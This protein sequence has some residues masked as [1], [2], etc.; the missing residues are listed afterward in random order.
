MYRSFSGS[1]A[2]IQQQPD[3]AARPERPTNGT[4]PG[5]PPGHRGPLRSASDRRRRGIATTDH[6]PSDANR[7][8]SQAVQVLTVFAGSRQSCSGR[9]RLGP[10]VAPASNKGL[11][12]G[13]CQPDLG[14]KGLLSWRLE[15]AIAPRASQGVAELLLQILQGNIAEMARAADRGPSRAPCSGN[16]TPAGGLC[17]SPAVLRQR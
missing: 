4:D 11:P 17:R 8:R 5:H 13:S 12:S 14:T 9:K 16:E 7:A 10:R 1:R 3:R 6:H 2:D 15:S